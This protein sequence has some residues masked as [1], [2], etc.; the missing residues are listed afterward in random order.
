MFKQPH[1][2]GWLGL[3]AVA[4]LSLTPAFAMTEHQKQSLQSAALEGRQI[5]LKEM[6]HDT[7][8]FVDC[9]NGLLAQEKKSD[10]RRLGLAYMGLVGCL[11]AARI[12]TL[13]SDVCSQD[14]LRLAD[15][16]RLKLN[17][18]DTELCPIVAGDC[19]TRI[20]QLRVLRAPR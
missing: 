14:Y 16:I 9:I 8:E 3:A 15:R 17:I 5:C 6:H 4:I 12:A 7:D 2:A 13:H 11:S 20:A 19:P 1:L 18:K 10:D